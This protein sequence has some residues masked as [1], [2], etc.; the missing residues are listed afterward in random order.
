ME[1]QESP[2]A[3]WGLGFLPLLCQ[4]LIPEQRRV[5]AGSTLEVGVV[6]D[7][8]VYLYP[9]PHHRVGAAAA[10][11][12]LRRGEMEQPPAAVGAARPRGCLHT[13][14]PS[15]HTPP[16]PLLGPGVVTGSPGRGSG[17]EIRTEARS[18]TWRL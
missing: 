8:A 13:H 4:D 15:T 14:I 16:S 7:A 10:L 1:G 12:E 2:P 11:W 9:S 5:T 17:R 6:Q 3:K 18:Y